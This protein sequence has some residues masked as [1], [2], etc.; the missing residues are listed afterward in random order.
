MYKDLVPQAN[1]LNKVIGLVFKVSEGFNNYQKIAD[2][3]EFTERQS[4]YY[5]EAAEALG[6]VVAETGTYELTDVGR[7]FVSMDTEQRNIFFLELLFDFHLVQAA[8][9]M[10]KKKGTL[11]KPDIEKIIE[12]NSSLSGTT[13]GRRADSLVAWFRWIA[14]HTSTFAE[15]DGGGFR[16]NP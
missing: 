7:R 9:D 10:L 11:L 5:R 6:L 16:L 4:S 14:E 13:I 8:T 12:K 1:D 3:L 15:A 2:Q